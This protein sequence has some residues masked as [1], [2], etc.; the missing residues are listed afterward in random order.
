ME[1]SPSDTSCKQSLVNRD[2]CAS[3]VH[4]AVSQL[5][6]ISTSAITAQQPKGGPVSSGSYLQLVTQSAKERQ[7]LLKLDAT[8]APEQ[9]VAKARECFDMVCERTGAILFF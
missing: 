6:N 4:S 5:G 3:R 8:V 7:F 2:L 1:V 9:L